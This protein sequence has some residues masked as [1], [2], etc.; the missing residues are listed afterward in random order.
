[1]NIGFWSNQLCERGT[2]VSMYDYAYYNEKIL[3][4]KSFIFYDKN[5]SNNNKIIEKFKKYFIVHETDDFK[6]VDE[7]LVKY[8]ISH[9]YIIKA[10]YLDSR[11]SKVAKNCIHC[12]FTCSQPHG[13]VYSS[14]APW[15][16][17]N[18]NK[19]PVVPHMVNLPKNNNNM[20]K[21]LNIPENA[22][23]FGGYG[24]KC[25][26]NIKFVHE[27]VYKI[28][29]QNSNIYFLFAN[30]T[31]FCPEMHNIIHLPPIYDLK[32][33]VEFINTCDAM[34]WARDDGETFGLAIAEFSYM[35]KPVISMK[36]GEL[37]HYYLLGDKGIW[38]SNQSD[39]E[40]IILNFNPDI[41]KNKDWNAYKD[42]TPEKVMNIFKEVFLEEKVNFIQKNN[43]E[44][45]VVKNKKNYSLYIFV[46]VLL[47]TL[48][49]MKKNKNN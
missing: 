30:F 5:S 6:E 32:N 42:Y 21:K 2:E 46:S 16:E 23:V 35:N 29:K 13:E 28:A 9:I 27:T 26:F 20:R 40:N 19:Y 47:F 1:M 11:L 17:G 44:G 18:D 49:F 22:I 45:L 37:A 34:I 24:G 25:R 48:F 8:N 7:Y 3:N 14:I 4:N 12:V 10:G 41:E 33:K 43:N 39:L 31:K 15:V 36:I 38:Y